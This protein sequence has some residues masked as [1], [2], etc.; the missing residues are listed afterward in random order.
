[1]LPV[2]RGALTAPKLFGLL[3][4]GWEQPALPIAGDVFAVLPVICYPLCPP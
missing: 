3:A 2:G 4:A 1:M